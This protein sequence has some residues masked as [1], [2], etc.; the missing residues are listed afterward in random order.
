[1]RGLKTLEMRAWVLFVC[2]DGRTDKVSNIL[3]N[4]KMKCGKERR[5]WGVLVQDKKKKIYGTEETQSNHE[6]KPLNGDQTGIRPRVDTAKP[7][8]KQ[9]GENYT[10]RQTRLT[11]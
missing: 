5:R 4:E 3:W 9:S 6:N 8:D 10:T 1:M 11:I 2:G 7:L